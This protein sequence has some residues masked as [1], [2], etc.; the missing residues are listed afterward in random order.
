MGLFNSK[1]KNQTNESLKIRASAIIVQAKAEAAL[2]N[3]S[4]SVIEFEKNFD[5]IMQHLDDLTYMY[6]VQ[7]VHMTISPRQNKTD[8]LK[9]MEATINDFIDRASS[10]TI[11]YNGEERAKELESLAHEIESSHV[12]SIYLTQSNRAKI[13][14]LR[15]K[16]NKIRGAKREQ[17]K[18]SQKI[19]RAQKQKEDF[20]KYLESIRQD[21]KNW[22]REQRGLSPIEEELEHID[23]MDGHAFEYWCSDLLRKNGFTNVSVTQGSGDQGVDVL[24]KKDDIKYAFQCKCYSSDLGN[25]T[26]QE[27][28]AGKAFYGCQVGVVITNRYFT[29]GA[30]ALAEK[31]GVLLWDRTGLV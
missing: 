10:Y 1:H 21:E 18:E 3:S 7:R 29:K 26:V 27:V 2:I 11:R 28:H 19:A 14:Q 20:E 17:I 22:I 9:N 4:K 24:A 13:E 6:E 25:T 23:K 30:Q 12:F 31:T 16:A 8:I 15:N 5:A